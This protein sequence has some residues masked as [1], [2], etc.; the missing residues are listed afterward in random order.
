M[1]P[2]LLPGLLAAAEAQP[3]SRLRRRGAVRARP[4]LSRRQARRISISRAAGVRAGTAKLSGQR[5]PLGRRRRAS[6]D[7]FDAKAD[8]F[9]VL[10]A[11][12]LRSRKAQITRDAPAWY[13]PGRS[14]T[15]RLGPKVVL[16]HFGELHPATLKA[17][18]VAGP[19]AGFE[20]FLDALPPRESEEPRQAARSRP[21]ICCRC[22]ATSPSCSIAPS[23]PATWCAPP[24]APTRR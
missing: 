10:A 22:G 21:P 1:R 18:D 6:V 15:L 8:V 11:L 24:P 20:V 9:A 4:G 16:A 13:H 3:Q 7:V 19:V 17:L 23:R 14:G 5:P 2:S 12:G